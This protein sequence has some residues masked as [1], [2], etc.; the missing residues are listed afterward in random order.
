M[1]VHFVGFKDSTRY[2]RAIQVFGQPD[3]VHRQW[4][5]RA[6]FGGEFDAENDYFVFCDV[7]GDEKPYEFAYD[8]SAH[9]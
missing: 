4:D 8:D 1:A 7:D 6:K 9:F 5:M 2:H 3:F